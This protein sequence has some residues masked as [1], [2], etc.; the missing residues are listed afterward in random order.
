[1]N[2]VVATI[3]ENPADLAGWLERR[4]VGLE[5][6][7]LVAE[8]TAIHKPSV[9]GLA[10]RDALNGRLD[11]VRESGLSCLSREQLRRLLRCPSLLLEL[12]E[13]VLIHG[14]PYWDNIASTMP[15]LYVKVEEGRRRLPSANDSS[16]LPRTTPR[17]VTRPASSWYHRTWLLSLATAA[18]VL[19]AVGMW[20]W[21]P[22]STPTVAWGWERPGAVN[23]EAAPATY[24][25]SLADSADEWF[26]QRPE[27]S[28]GLAKR[29]GQMRQGCSALIRAPH[30]PLSEKDKDWLVNRCKAWSK[31]FD[32]ALVSLDDGE[33]VIAVRDRMDAVVK[34]L[35]G[36]LRE[37]AKQV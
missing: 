28:A 20:V 33:D 25:S 9:A 24:L 2:L 21:R 31:E 5:L 29:I 13:E 23:P 1:M 8:L 26:K 19:I 7:G 30:K 14:G 12:Q 35:A 37:R 18:L 16:N 32:S 3:P 34:K 4:L 36:A 22:A 17:L 11:E 15:M 10:L 6:D 27:D